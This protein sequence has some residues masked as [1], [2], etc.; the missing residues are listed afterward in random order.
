MIDKVQR[1]LLIRCFQVLVSFSYYWNVHEHLFKFQKLKYKNIFSAIKRDEIL[2]YATLMDLENI[3]LSEISP[4]QKVKYY[5]IS[6]ICR[7]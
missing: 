4:T 2:I 7:T 3:M 6:L 5:I 1:P